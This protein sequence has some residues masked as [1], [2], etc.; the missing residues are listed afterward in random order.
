MQS[1]RSRTLC[2]VAFVATTLATSL[3]VRASIA[4]PAQQ[5]PDDKQRSAARGLAN[6]GLAAFNAGK[7]A[8]AIDLFGRAE[9]LVHAPPHLLYIARAHAA[10][11]RLVQ[12]HETYVKITREDLASNA[13]KPFIE[14]KK[15]AAEEQ[16]KLEPRIPKLTIVLKGGTAS[17]NV[18]MDDVEVPAALVG[19]P[20]KVDPGTHTL[21]AKGAGFQSKSDV[22][23]KLAEGASETA[24]IELVEDKRA[25]VATE[26]TAGPA[27]E[28]KSGARIAPWIAFGIGAAGLGVGTYFLTENRS[29]RDEADG[30]CGAGPCPA[31]R[32]DEIVELD[33][34]ADSAATVAWIGYGVGAT[35]VIAGAVLLIVG[36]KSASPSTATALE[37]T[38]F[39]SGGTSAGMTVRF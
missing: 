5:Q 7:H 12:A 2:R 38:H 8:E 1:V 25:A 34:D 6:E 31:A 3:G 33:K 17:P 20:H 29:K 10:L 36:R 19:V 24:T 37:R 13:P 28:K 15:S 14:A 26:G 30:I 11:G 27:T 21:R 39:W 23:V 22:V 4:Q 18:T 9:A 16:G 32:R 35:G